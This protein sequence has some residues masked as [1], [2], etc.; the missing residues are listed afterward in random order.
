[1]GE[2]WHN[3]QLRLVLFALAEIAC[4]RWKVRVL[5]WF[6]RPEITVAPPV[7]DN[8][9]KCFTG[10]LFGHELLLY[11]KTPSVGKL[12]VL[13]L[14][15]ST[16]WNAEMQTLLHP[17]SDVSLASA[18][19]CFLVA[20]LQLRQR[21]SHDLAN[22]TCKYLPFASNCFVSKWCSKK[23]RRKC[24]KKPRAARI[25]QAWR[26]LWY[27]TLVAP[28][29]FN[30]RRAVQIAVETEHYPLVVC[31]ILVQNTEPKD[32]LSLFRTPW[33]REAEMEAFR[34]SHP[35]GMTAPTSQ[36]LPG[37]HGRKQAPV[38]S[39]S[40]P[41]V[42][43]TGVCGQLTSGCCSPWAT[44]NL[45]WTCCGLS[46]KTDRNFRTWKLRLRCYLR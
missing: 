16:F 46:R 26:Q 42:T 18:L 31:C 12:L 34:A 1:M 21:C 38:A 40:F 14:R 25:V 35:V 2:A 36:D 24:N 9:K 45:S 22:N 33:K 30:V 4:V 5:S 37:A 7:W 20:I 27:G 10:L 23:N 29:L 39:R 13:L 43:S 6:R 8:F 3:T 32:V 11:G 28:L 41:N 19:E 44:V 17:F 15:W